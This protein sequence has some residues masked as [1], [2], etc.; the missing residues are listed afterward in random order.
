VISAPRLAWLQLRRETLRLA[1]AVSGVAF[2]VVLIF[3]QLGFSDALFTSAVNVH[4]R[5]DGDIFFISPHSNYLATMKVF[6]RRRLYQALGFEG[7]E[8]VTPVYTLLRPW[9]NPWN[10]TARDIFVIGVDPAHHVFTVPEMDA[11]RQILKRPD[12]VLYDEA[13]RPEFGPVAARV[14]A[15]ETVSTEVN[16]R[17]VTIAGLFRMGTSFGIDGTI[18][19]SDLN[20]LRMF[21]E[22]TPGLISIGVIKLKPG[23]DPVAMERTL[24]AHLDKDVLVLTKDAYIAREKDYWGRATPI[25]YVFNFGVI[26]GLVVG[27]IIVYQILFADISDHLAEYATL[28]AMGYRNRYLVGVVLMEA[29]ILAAIGYLPGAAICVWL[30]RLTESAT[31]LPMRM[32]VS[33]GALVLVLTVAMCAISG[34]IAV[35]KIRSADPAE[36]F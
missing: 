9:V 17:H 6:S 1:I 28:K 24:A 35:R 23:V 22:R 7:V 20:F 3:M 16:R 32:R 13:S 14:K 8:S 11:G 33:T 15:G 4:R 12:V 10:G 21:P 2:A 26:M 5:L 27:G 36:I 29:I 19:T 18:V 34:L 25:G 30:Y 31:Q